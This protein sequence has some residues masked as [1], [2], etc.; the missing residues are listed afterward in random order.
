[1]SLGRKKSGK[2]FTPEDLD[3]LKTIANQSAIALENA[4]LF[5]ENI[6]KSRMEEELKIVHDIQMSMLPE[7]APLIEGFTIA[8]RFIPAREVGGD[9]YDFIEVRGDGE[10]AQ[11]ALVVGDA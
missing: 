3:L 9:F 8:A 4:K 1:I 7:K 10:G 11:L 5:A 6:E 2:M